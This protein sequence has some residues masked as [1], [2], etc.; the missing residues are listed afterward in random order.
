[1]RSTSDSTVS[2]VR[3]RAKPVQVFFY[4]V[5]YNVVIRC[6]RVCIRL[7]KVSTRFYYVFIRFDMF[8]IK[9]DLGDTILTFVWLI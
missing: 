5:S 3:E 6:Y 9:L 2:Q 8:F 4:K 1:M 7:Y